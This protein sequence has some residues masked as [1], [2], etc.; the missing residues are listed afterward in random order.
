MSCCQLIYISTCR[1]PD[2]AEISND[3]LDVA[4]SENA[5]ND[6][7]GLLL[8]SAPSFLQVLEGPE[9]AVHRLFKNIQ[10]D[11][12]HEEVTPLRR[13]LVPHRAFPDWSMAWYCPDDDP[14]ARAL[15]AEISRIQSV[16]ALGLDGRHGAERAHE[17]ITLLC[18]TEPPSDHIWQPFDRP[19]AG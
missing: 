16:E 15:S 3:I 8:F 1:S 12:R 17:L 19:A 18:G 13:R 10:A 9:L 2:V 5:R 7:T 6:I 11:E 4:R 14:G